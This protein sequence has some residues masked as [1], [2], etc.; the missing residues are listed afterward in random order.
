M[1]KNPIKLNRKK[2][3][4]LKD[5]GIKGRGVFCRDDIAAG[6]IIETTPSV[7]LD[8]S[9]T[10]HVDKTILVNYTFTTGKISKRA[11]ER[12]HIKKTGTCCSVIMGITSFCNHGE[13]PNAEVLWMEHDGTLYYQLRATRRILKNTEICTSYGPG[14]FDDRQ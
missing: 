11:R 4:Y 1:A 5:A 9:A 7:I 2:N 14:W 12:M 13:K 3:L 8:T 6:T 10:H